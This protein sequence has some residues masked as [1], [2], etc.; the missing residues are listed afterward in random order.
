MLTLCWVK[1]VLQGPQLLG[2]Q[3]QV[4]AKGVLR[5][6]VAEP[7]PTQPKLECGHAQPQLVAELTK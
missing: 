5:H 7:N 6:K 4:L 2:V 1:D 3:D